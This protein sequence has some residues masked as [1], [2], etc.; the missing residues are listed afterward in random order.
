MRVLLIDLSKRFGGADVRVLQT[1]VNMPAGHEAA[2][3]VLEGSAIHKDATAAGVRTFPLGFSRHDPRHAFALARIAR[4]FRADVVDAH[5]PQSQLWGMLAA[6]LAGVR[7]QV[8]TVHTVYREAHRGPIRQ[9]GHEFAI[10][11]AKHSNAR[12]LTVSE[13]IARYLHSFGIAAGRVTVSYNAMEPLSAVPKGAGLKR[14]LG[15]TEG[16]LLLGM[17]GRIEMVKGYDI[18]I[19]AIDRLRKAGQNF[20]V[21]IAGEGHDTGR[22]RAI[23]AERGMENRFH[24]L[25]FRRD[26]PDVLAD[27]DMLCVPSRSEGLPYTVLE[28]AR[29]GV[30]IIATSVDGL[31]EVLEDGRTAIVIPPEN[32][33]ALANAI[34]RAAADCDLRQQLS[35]AGAKMIVERFSIPRMIAETLAVYQSAI[36]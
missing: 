30:P 11:L 26:I 20:H 13:S 10:R 32:S 23:I 19:D 22:I 35:E 24:F 18:M 28:A 16:E 21:A 9:R 29:Q 1:A 5:N 7:G 34:A 2:I 25:G 36:T 14:S 8:A 6:R 4:E 27:Y 17:V 15:L 33:E 31:G 12:F 3:A